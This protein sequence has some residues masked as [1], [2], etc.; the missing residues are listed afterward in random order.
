MPSSTR[1]STSSR[2]SRERPPPSS[3]AP[4]ANAFRRFHVRPA[5]RTPSVWKTSAGQISTP[6]HSTPSSDEQ[7]PDPLAGLDAVEIRRGLDLHDPVAV[8]AHRPVER[9]DERER[10]AQRALRLHRD[11]HVD[12]ADLEPD[13]TLLEERQPRARED[14]RLAEPPLAVG[15]LHQQ[16]DVRVG[17]HAAK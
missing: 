10:L 3:A 5:I 15:E 1:R 4:S 16:V 13:A 8:L 7:Q 12:R 11:V 17:D 14:V 9:G 6:K 2:P